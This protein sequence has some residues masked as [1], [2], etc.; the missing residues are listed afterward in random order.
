MTV[1]TLN[2]F[3]GA[4]PYLPPFLRKG[5]V[6]LPIIEAAKWRNAAVDRYFYDVGSL[7]DA[8]RD[9]LTRQSNIE[10]SILV[11]SPSGVRGEM[12]IVKHDDHDSL[13]AAP[14]ESLRRFSI[15]GVGSS[16]FGAA[17]LARNIADH[18]KEPVGAIVAGY[19]LTDV[20]GESFGGWFVLGLSNRFLKFT[21]DWRAGNRAML[22][23]F[24][25]G[26]EA[27]EASSVAT[28]MPVTGSPDSDTLI[29]LLLDED[30]EI[31]SV[32][33]HSKGCLSIAFAL[34]AL[35]RSDADPAIKAKAKQMRIVTVGAVV[36]MPGGYDNTTQFL[37]QI[38]WLGL[39]NSRRGV[40][41]ELVMG[42]G[43]HLNS[44]EPNH[45]SIAKVLV[46]ADVLA[47]A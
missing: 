2:P 6:E 4:S 35:D 9:M 16:D 21:S 34:D 40:K 29:K 31:K 39:V 25:N 37:G 10:G 23:R 28:G 3:F 8:E 1:A 11:V 43:H 32:L 38:D 46:R 22:M 14:G 13:R 15:A 36:E 30:R 44:N 33:G 20:I 27:E 45:L 19:G 42:A 47:A 18:Y 24:A 5:P 26:G 41:R 12:G 7:T 17:A